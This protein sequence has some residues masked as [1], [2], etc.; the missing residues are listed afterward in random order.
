MPP[1]KVVLLTDSDSL[2]PN[3]PLPYKYY[4]QKLWETI[5]TIVYD[6]NYSCETV[7]LHKLD[8]QEHE[9]VNKFLNAD[10]VVTS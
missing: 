3:I 8:F 10:I 9:S 7:E 6:L 5:Q 2:N 1:L 4:G